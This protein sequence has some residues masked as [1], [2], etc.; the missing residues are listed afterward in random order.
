M[1]RDEAETQ[2]ALAQLNRLDHMMKTYE[3]A[4]D[5]VD[6]YGGETVGQALSMLEAKEAAMIAGAVHKVVNDYEDDKD[7]DEEL[8]EITDP[9]PALM[10]AMIK[11]EEEN[12]ANDDELGPAVR[13]ALKNFRGGRTQPNI[14]I[15]VH[16]TKISDT[17]NP[18]NRHNREYR[19][20]AHLV[21]TNS[22]LNKL[23]N[24]DFVDRMSDD[25]FCQFAEDVVYEESDNIVSEN[26]SN[27]IKM[28][29]LKKAALK[30]AG[31]N[32]GDGAATL[33]GIRERVA[34]RALTPAQASIAALG[35]PSAQA[36]AAMLPKSWTDPDSV[37]AM[38]VEREF[39][40][41]SMLPDEF[42][43]KIEATKDRSFGAMARS[44]KAASSLKN[45]PNHEQSPAN[46]KT[47]GPNGPGLPNVDGMTRTELPQ[48][49]TVQTKNYVFPG[50]KSNFP[51]KEKNWDVNLK[52]PRDINSGNMDV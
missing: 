45:Q 42:K 13:K 5:L 12:L 3:I 20:W 8:D 1:T 19:H 15:G 7:I 9:D 40:T 48:P 52:K 30:R 17:R 51:N 10:R 39:N 18:L 49:A 36:V 27:I 35:T 25:E 23:N 16:R 2:T 6:C 21:P 22:A 32:G 11:I 4:K 31:M 47:Y 46:G 33:E 50:G 14:K 26:V 24:E 37:P 29:M 34:A 38:P 43:P 44:T 28:S 41:R